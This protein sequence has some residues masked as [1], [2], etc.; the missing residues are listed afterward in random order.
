MVGGERTKPFWGLG[1]TLSHEHFF[2]MQAGDGQRGLEFPNFIF[3]MCWLEESNLSQELLVVERIKERGIH[4]G[5]ISYNFEL[6][7]S[8]PL[9]TW[10]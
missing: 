4:A 7:T 6:E 10:R 3:M 1:E 9:K 5:I 2:Q 8:R